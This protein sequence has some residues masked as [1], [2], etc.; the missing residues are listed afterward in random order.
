MLIEKLEGLGNFRCVGNTD[1]I[2]SKYPKERHQ[3]VR[4]AIKEW[5]ALT[6]YETEETSYKAV[7]SRDVNNYIALKEEGDQQAK[8]LCDRLG[9]K[10]KGDLFRTWTTEEPEHNICTDS[11][12]GI[13]W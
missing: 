3:D 11:V 12:L 10:T 9:A 8:K 13:P 2:V 6:G 5:E 1:G 7:Y 4:N